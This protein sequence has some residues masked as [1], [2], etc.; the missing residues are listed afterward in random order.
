[1]ALQ[2]KAFTLGNIVSRFESLDYNTSPVQVTNAG[3]EDLTIN[4]GDP[5][6]ADGIATSASDKLL[7]LATDFRIIKAGETDEIT[8]LD[9]N[10][11]YGVILNGS[12]LP[13]TVT[14]PIKALLIGKGFK[15]LP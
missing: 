3:T 14:E 12:M 10:Y 7:G 15:I 11:G 1:M 2:E 5:L 6:T 9:F 13:D 4:A 8:V